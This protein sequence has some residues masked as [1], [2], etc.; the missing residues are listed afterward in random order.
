MS[1][2]NNDMQQNYCKPKADLPMSKSKQ[3]EQ[4]DNLCQRVPNVISI[5]GV[6]VPKATLDMTHGKK[7]CIDGQWI[8]ST[9]KGEQIATFQSESDLV[10]WWMAVQKMAGGEGFASQNWV[11]SHGRVV[12]QARAAVAQR[13]KTVSRTSLQAQARV[14]AARDRAAKATTLKESQESERAARVQAARARV[15]PVPPRVPEPGASP[16]WQSSGDG[17]SMRDWDFD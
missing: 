10:K 13:M 5:I 3:S 7:I 12:M 9:C 15:A 17:N 2:Q 11:A 14:Q 4:C 8:L 1:D 6:L 16:P